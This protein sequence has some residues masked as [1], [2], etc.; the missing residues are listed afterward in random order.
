MKFLCL[1]LVGG[2]AT[3]DLLA[4]ASAVASPD[5]DYTF[6]QFNLCGQVSPST[7]PSCNGGEV[8][9]VAG[10]IVQSVLNRVPEAV[11]LNEA[12]YSQVEEVRQ[13]LVGSAWPMNL[14]WVP[15]IE[16]TTNCGQAADGGDFGNA[17]LLRQAF[18]VPFSPVLLPSSGEV[19][20]L[21]CAQAGIGNQT[22]L[23]CVTHVND[24]HPAD[25]A[26]NNDLGPSVDVILATLDPFLAMA[27]RPILIGGDFNALP[28]APALGRLYSHVQGAFREVDEADNEPTT[29]SG[30]LDY[31]F[32][33]LPEWVVL[34]GDA[35]HSAYSDHDPLIGMAMLFSPSTTL[36]LS[37]NR[38]PC[39][40]YECVDRLIWTQPSG[41]TITRYEVWVEAAPG[42]GED[43]YSCGPTRRIASVPG[44]SPRELVWPICGLT[45]GYQVMF[46]S[47]DQFRYYVKAFSGVDEIARGYS[48]LYVG[49]LVCDP[50]C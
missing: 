9:G 21:G 29:H 22:S 31:L 18:S 17:I 14:Y 23:F 8:Q 34:D 25:T 16:D 11:T 35:T 27:N 7:N 1:L 2:L 3:F 37:D 46:G 32:L 13:A 33:S 10:A 4:P 36:I 47:W 12:C 43:G 20:K 30:K 15:T 40:Y 5:P 49:T 38:Q 44:G 19:R 39:G 24:S 6:M 48:A 28:D 42:Y 45:M 26:I 50:G 41:V